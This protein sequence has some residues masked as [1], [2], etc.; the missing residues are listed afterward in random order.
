MPSLN[1]TLTLGLVLILLFGAVSLYLY[2]RVQQCEQKL[3]LV[4]SILLDIKM[5]AE[6]REYPDLPLR[7]MESAF[8]SVPVSQQAAAPAPYRPSSR[9]PSPPRT[10]SP[11][12][13]LE[14]AVEV[15]VAPFTDDLAPN[16]I[17]NAGEREIA[18][19]LVAP[20]AVRPFAGEDHSLSVPS[21]Q[22]VPKPAVASSGAS[23]G[24]N[25]E[26]MTLSDLKALAAQRNITGAKSMKRAQIL[27]ALRTSDRAA[28]A[29]PI[30]EVQGFS[31]FD[32]GA[33]E[34]LS[35]IAEHSSHE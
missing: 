25:Y 5:S 15:A 11:V 20:A 34:E 35:A 30:G 12:N 33:V 8:A 24:A 1:D 19:R 17:V 29:Q 7:P 9:P 31:T 26:S 6:L 28:E 10:S 27:E 13:H 16:G 2:T 14:E 22:P 32:A 23:V 21:A 4:E 18:E 3:N